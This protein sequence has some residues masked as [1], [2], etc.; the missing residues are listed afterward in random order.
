MPEL[1]VKLYMDKLLKVAREAAKPLSLLSGPIKDKALHAMA[2]RL[3]AD[4]EAILGANK[5][6]VET[7]GKAMAADTNKDRIRESVARLRTTADDVKEMADCLRRVADLPDPVGEVTSRWEEPNG[8]QVSRV[9][10]PI[11]V[12]GVISEMKPL[13]MVESV[14]LCLKSGNVCVFR[15][16]PEWGKTQQ[17]ITSGLREAAERAGVPAGALSFVER[18]EKEAALE[19]IRATKVLDAIVPRGGAGLRKVVLEQARMPVLC[20]D[21]GISHMYIDGEVDLPLAQNLAVNSKVQ[22]AAAANSIDTLLVHQGIARPLLP[23]LIL[24]LLDEFK[25]EVLGCP[26]TVSLMGQ[27]SM[28][29]H[30]SVKPA[31]DEDWDKQFQSPTLAVKMVASMQEALDHI[32][33]HGPSQTDVIV[34]KNYE[35]AMRFTREVAAAAVLVNASSRLH[36]GEPFGF[37][38]D[39][40]ISISRVYAKGPIGLE[41]LTAEKYVV[42]GTGQLRQPHPVPVTYEDAIMLKRPS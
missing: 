22:Q 21:G 23:A 33:Q 13:V 5:Q 8:M 20:H 41:Q 18:S 6:D 9:R 1:P 3:L 24:R 29:G 19:L 31:G 17:V 7:V 30:K 32:S 11:G 10:V 14:A 37:G 4:E 36:G 40:G 42:F 34:T 2:D 39:M 26:K 12:I 15:G 38:A 25:V 28:S 35:S 27:M 16:A